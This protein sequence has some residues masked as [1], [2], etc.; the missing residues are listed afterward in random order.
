MVQADNQSLPALYATTT[1]GHYRDETLFA[2]ERATLFSRHWI[3]VG[4]TRDVPTLND[5]FLTEV[6]GHNIIIQNTG[7]GIKAF[8]NSCSHRHSRI[9][10]QAQGN[11]RLICPYHGWCYDN[12]GIPTGIPGKVNF[13]Q[14]CAHPEKFA[15]RQFEL[16]TAGHFIFVRLVPGNTDLKSFLGESYD[17]LVNA[18]LGLDKSMDDFQGTIAANWKNVIENA[19]EGYHVPMVHRATLG[20]I[21]Q[22]STSKNDIV[23]HLPEACGH[24]Y[25]TNK[26]NEKWLRKWQ[27]YERALGTWPFKFSHYVH[28]LIFPNL[29]VTSFMGYC[30]HIQQFRPDAVD[31][32]TVHSRIYSVAC[33]GQ[34]EQGES[35]MRT[36]YDEGKSF[37]RA[38]FDEDRRICELVFKGL[39]HTDSRAVLASHLEKRIA[40]FQ[41]F[42]MKSMEE[43][44]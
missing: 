9:H 40:H 31:Q 1:P 44:A 17:F 16:S 20:A 35:I 21:R 43:T 23:D 2:K 33:T 3:Y 15:L 34:T 11:R 28:Q 5:Y 32:T 6:A 8:A 41:Q 22:F 13:P 25:M 4:L 24:S 10:E 12:E 19:L 30:F 18:S 38:V 37:T 29:T 42:Y 26:A 27:R 36:V 39:Q 14:V 7:L